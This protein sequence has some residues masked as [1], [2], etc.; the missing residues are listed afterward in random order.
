MKLVIVETPAQAKT[1]AASLGEGWRVEPCYGFVRDLPPNTLGVE[2]DT[3]FRPTFSIVPGKG[4]IVIRLKKALREAD[5][6]Y[7]ATPPG[8]DGEAMVW[9]VLALL[10]E[11]QARPVYRVMLDALTPG[12]IRDAFASPLP[13][14]MNRVDAALTARIA[15]R[16]A[17]FTVNAAASKALGS[18]TR[19]TYAGMV[20]LR[21][22][23]DREI[24]ASGT[25][26]SCS[27]RF[28]LG[29]VSF[30]AKVL[31]AKGR[32]L[33]LRSRLQT[34]QLT[35]MLEHSH[36]WVE[37]I[38]G[39]TR[40][41]P[42]PDPLTLAALIELA[43]RE[44]D[45]SATRTV[46]LVAT[47][48][49]AG[50]ITHPD[51]IPLPDATATAQAFIEP[52]YGAGYLA[53]SPAI[54]NG[55]APTDVNRRPEDVPGDG[56]ALYGLIWRHFVAAHMAP[57][58]ER[59]TAARIRVGPAHNKPYPVTLL[60]QSGRIAFDGWMRVFK[61]RERDETADWLPLLKEGVAFSS[62]QAEIVLDQRPMAERFTEPALAAALTHSGFSAQAAV[63]AASDLLDSSL[64]AAN[65]GALKLTD[66]GLRIASYLK[67]RFSKLTDPAYAAEFFTGVEAIAAGEQTRAGVLAEFWLRCTGADS[68]PEKRKVPQSRKPV[69]LHTLEEA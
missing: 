69:T 58:Q 25:Y 48:Y 32:P 51:G 8:C 59:I 33:A 57:A 17:G 39:T 15:D 47:L 21:L 63:E 49:E 68:E 4:G 28:S 14:D 5:A 52:E 1:L 40:A 16:I 60:A 62:A 24:R 43:S 55:I 42:A 23:D 10:P 34:D 45:L 56:S 7:A 11:A 18:K 30:D 67:E 64:I 36:Y 9:H 29:D 26:W 35:R 61:D 46:A 65:D 19:L 6:I 13:L 50:W 53:S 54:S 3:G 20:A 12:A 27:V 44:F 2:V 22:L 66:E 41:I 37:K 31:N 38:G